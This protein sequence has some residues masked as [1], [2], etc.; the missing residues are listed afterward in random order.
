MGRDNRC[1][2]KSGQ[3]WP[4]EAQGRGEWARKGGVRWRPGN[5]PWVG[6]IEGVRLAARPP[7]GQLLPTDAGNSQAGE[8][9]R[10]VLICTDNRLPTQIAG[11]P[12]SGW[13]GKCAEYQYAVEDR[14]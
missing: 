6:K 13:A 14:G 1:E 2:E 4:N 8:A 3:A 11:K 10:P 7:T 9:D 12:A 5:G